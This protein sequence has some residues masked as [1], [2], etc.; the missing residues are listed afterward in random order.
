MPRQAADE[1]PFTFT[2]RSWWSVADLDRKPSYLT[3]SPIRISGPLNVEALRS[4][5]AALVRRHEAL[6]TKIV[7]MDGVPKQ[8]IDN[9]RDY[10]LRVIDLSKLLQVEQEAELKRLVKITGWGRIDISVDP[11]FVTSL[12]RLAVDEHVL[13]IA[14]NHLISDG[15]AGII[16][17]RE[18]WELYR[19]FMTGTATLLPRIAMQ[20][21]DYAV[22][23][24]KSDRYWTEKHGGYWKKHLAGALR[25]RTSTAERPLALPKSKWGQY[26]IQL[27]RDLVSSLREVSRQE[28]TIISLTVLSA[29][30]ASLMRWATTNDVVIPVV[31][32]GR[33]FPEFMHTV[34]FFS[35][36][37]YL[38]ISIRGTESLCELLRLVTAAY[39]IAC[40]H[41]DFG[42]IAASIPKPE[43]VVNPAFNWFPQELD[44]T[45]KEEIA[46]EAHGCWH[47]LRVTPTQAFL[48]YV[49]DELFDFESE[50]ELFGLTLFDSAVGVRGSFA[51][52]A[53]RVSAS[54]IERFGA[55]FQLFLEAFANDPNTQVAAVARL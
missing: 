46:F 40:A 54:A 53:H 55:T 8:E 15:A 3:C 2:Q 22:W 35:A 28:H 43:F 4:S 29:Y 21:A 52:H 18:L 49:P 44:W 37:L 19:E 1:I 45:L 32:M 16:V 23:L 7:L 5:I 27:G 42:R 20:F 24:R 38:R 51:Y 12:Y 9:S 31:T 14:R 36:L 33:Q 30:A 34:G 17:R 50:C 25:L 41:H 11:L 6:R 26:D 47:H 13:V 39:S 10:G 48:E